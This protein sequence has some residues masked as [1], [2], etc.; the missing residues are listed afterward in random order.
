MTNDGE[1]W[2]AVFNGFYEVSDLGRVRNAKTKRIFN[3][4]CNNSGYLFVTLHLEGK[5]SLNGQKSYAV[6][7]LVTMAFLPNP[8]KLSSVNHINGIKTDNRLKNL[9]WCTRSE[10]QIHATVTGLRKQA[11][12]V[13][14]GK[15]NVYMSAGDAARKLGVF[16]SHVIRVCNGELKQAKGHIFSYVE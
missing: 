7:R 14:D 13:I 4:S 2:K 15:G 3:P 12:R 16:P 1:V 5:V 6:H 8:E 9:E 11:K 10:N